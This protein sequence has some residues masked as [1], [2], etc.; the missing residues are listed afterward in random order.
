MA[1]AFGTGTLRSRL[2]EF[3]ELVLAELPGVLRIG[4][5]IHEP[6]TG[7]LGFVSIRSDS[8]W[9]GQERFGSGSRGRSRPRRAGPASSGGTESKNSLEK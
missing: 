8:T 7:M 9:R 3:H 4:V 1:E 6:R 2:V 5:A